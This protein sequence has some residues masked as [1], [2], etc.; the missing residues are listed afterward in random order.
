MHLA[1]LDFA[2]SIQQADSREAAWFA[3]S[4]QLKSIGFHS[5]RYSAVV[6]WRTGQHPRPRCCYRWQFGDLGFALHERRMFVT[7]LDIQSPIAHRCCYRLLRISCFARHLKRPCPFPIGCGLHGL[8]I[9]I[10]AIHVGQRPAGS[11]L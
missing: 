7:L 5:A 4:Q 6:A 2:T 9:A 11:N 1:V 10:R 8:G 3:L